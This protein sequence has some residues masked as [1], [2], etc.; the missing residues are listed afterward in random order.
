[1]KQADFFNHGSTLEELK[2]LQQATEEA[3][4]DDTPFAVVSKEGMSVV[5]DVNKTEVKKKSYTVRFKFTPE[6]VEKY[7]IR[8]EDI[9]RYVGKYAEVPMEFT[10]VSIKPRYE[11]EIDAAIM[12]IYPYIYTVNEETKRI[13]ERSEEEMRLMVQDMSIEIGDDLYNFVAAVLG[14]DR[15]IVENM[16]WNDV[17]DTATQIFIDFPEEINSSEGFSE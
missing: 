8:E 12:K 13:G 6:E 17:M 2:K 14:V 1:M 16:E 11:L 7:G 9:T 3:K 10:D 15:R 4:K 5:G